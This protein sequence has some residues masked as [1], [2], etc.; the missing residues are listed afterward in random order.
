MRVYIAGPM[1]GLP[2]FNYPAFHA[3]AAEWRAAGWTVLNPAENMGGDQGRPYTDYIRRD[4][5]DLLV[6]DA[7]ALLPGWEK[8]KGASLEQHIATVLDLPIYD[9]TAVAAP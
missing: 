4:M 9:A 1:T 5:M 8:S 7:L 2:D 3:A 6:S